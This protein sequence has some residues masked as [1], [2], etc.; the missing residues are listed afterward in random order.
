MRSV[1]EHA[2][3][4][5]PYLQKDIDC[6]QKVQRKG[7]HMVKSNYDYKNSVTDM[8]NELDWISVADRRRDIRLFNYK[9]VHGLVAI[10]SEHILTTA[11][12][13]TRSIHEEKKIQTT[14]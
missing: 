12:I 14:V 4:W 8:I 13:R 10:P 11:D 6:I 5:D 7:V 9:I 3:A 2:V 1:L